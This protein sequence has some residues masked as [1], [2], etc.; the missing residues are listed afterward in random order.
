[1]KLT[2]VK[3]INKQMNLIRNLLCQTRV[4]TTIL[5]LKIKKMQKF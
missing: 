3:M 1:M 2:R 4:S 5:L